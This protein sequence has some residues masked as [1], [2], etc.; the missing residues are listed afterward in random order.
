LRNPIGAPFL[1]LAL[2]AFGF[3]PAL[4]DDPV[5]TYT[6]VSLDSD[7]TM[8][9]S[10][11][12]VEIANV[13]R[14]V[15]LL[16]NQESEM[17]GVEDQG[18]QTFERQSTNAGNAFAALG[19][20]L[21][22]AAVA[23]ATTSLPAVQDSLATAQAR[24]NYLESLQGTCGNNNGAQQQQAIQ[25]PAQQ[26]GSQQQA[27]APTADPYAVADSARDWNQIVALGNAQIGANANDPHAY[28]MRGYGEEMLRQFGHAVE[29]YTISLRLSPN[30][31]TALEKRA[32]TYSDLHQDDA[33]FADYSVLF[34]LSPNFAGAYCDRGSLYLRRKQYPDAIA[35]FQTAIKDFPGFGIARYLLGVAHLRTGQAKLGAAEIAKVKA[36]MPAIVSDIHTWLP[37]APVK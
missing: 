12:N 8:N 22:N 18:P 3:S 35:D 10:D 19:N 24:V 6:S 13:Q 9:C 34:P 20:I 29:D 15:S 1:A 36:E 21:G 28:E 16:E 4:A 32:R 11:L 27:S 23:D 2:F 17:Q 14:D 25:Q 33:A 37:D 26:P 31:P 5:V 30:N 7:R